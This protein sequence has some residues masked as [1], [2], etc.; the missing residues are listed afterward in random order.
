MR[1]R[2]LS[3]ALV[4]HSLILVRGRV[5]FQYDLQVAIAQCSTFPGALLLSLYDDRCNGGR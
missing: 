4:A 2:Y 3:L 1:M 5:A